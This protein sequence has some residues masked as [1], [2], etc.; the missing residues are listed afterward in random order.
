MAAPTRLQIEN[1]F[2][3]P[4]YKVEVLNH[5]GT[6]Y[7]MLNAR[8]ANLSGSADST[9]NQDNGVSFGT[10]SDPSASVD[11]ENY[12][13]DGIRYMHDPYWINK[14]VRISFGFDTSDFITVFQGPIVS[15]NRSNNNISLDLGGSLDY[16]AD[17]KLHTPIYYRRP[18]A[19]QTTFASQENPD[20][21]G[22]NAGLI[23]LALWRAGGRP[24]EQ[25][26]ILYT[27]ASPDWKFW[28]SCEQSLIA[29]DYAWY[30]GENLQDEVY[31]L[32]RAVGGQLY[33]DTLGTVR[34][35]QPLSFGDTSGYVSYFTFTDAHFV[36]Y[37]ENITKGELVG[38]L[39]MLHT[40]RRIEPMQD[41]IDDTT[42]RLI[43]PFALLG[44]AETI[45]LAPSLP[46]YQYQGLV[47]FDNG[48]ATRTMKAQLI[49]GREVT[50]VIGV[51]EQYANKVLITVSNPDGTTPMIITSIKIQ[52]R[53]LAANDE[54]LTQYPP[55]YDAFLPEK[56]VE[57]NVYVQN[58]V[59]AKRLTRMIY[60]FYNELRP[61]ISLGGVMYD[62]DRFVGEIVK[63][64]STY[65]NDAAKY[66]RIIKIGHEQLGTSMS[67]DLVQTTTIPKRNDM[68]IIG[69]TYS[70][71]DVRQLS[72]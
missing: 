41:V 9:G 55:P 31:R 13:V 61:I 53:P 36:D 30:S 70:S 34:Y 21:V 56:T 1:N 7:T 16:L 24:L 64:A 68:F 60:D 65:N 48:T 27:E 54:I 20:G 10:P 43:A 11:M 25:K 29:P 71:G 32:A 42:P 72:Y 6:W 28:Y 63:I 40:P 52:G 47:S 69:D 62:P 59:H 8:I 5:A 67:V 12:Q 45:E 46:V 49:D 57:N 66:F 51:V 35:T 22:Y 26:G 23:N 33:Q 37:A 18:A 4:T 14:V 19:T 2:A 17:V 39:K 44:Q 3:K 15:M 38:T 50:P 58:E